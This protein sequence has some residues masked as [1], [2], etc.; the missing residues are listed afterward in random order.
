MIVYSDPPVFPANLDLGCG[1]RTL[2]LVAPSEAAADPHP[3]VRAGFHLGCRYRS[4]VFTAAGQNRPNVAG[5]PAFG[6]FCLPAAL[7]RLPLLLPHRLSR[8]WFGRVFGLPGWHGFRPFF[9]WE[10]VLSQGDL[11]FNSVMMT[12]MLYNNPYNPRVNS[13]RY[14]YVVILSP[15]EIEEKHCF[16]CM[17][18]MEIK[19]ENT[20]FKNL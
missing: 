9:F 1:S 20:N 15:E 2:A 3:G 19:D 11:I 18:E 4:M 13:N 5:V 17:E 14:R 10:R 7:D 6:S 12:R 8:P 16:E